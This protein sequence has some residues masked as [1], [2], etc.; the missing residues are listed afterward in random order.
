M[1]GARCV[2]KQAA[3]ENTR[4]SQCNFSGQVRAVKFVSCFVSAWRFILCVCVCVC[5]FTTRAREKR[6]CEKYI[7][8]NFEGSSFRLIMPA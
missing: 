8:F 3:N 7:V 2:C 6:V 1:V 4:S 5:V